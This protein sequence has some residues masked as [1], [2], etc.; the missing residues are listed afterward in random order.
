[1]RPL[2]LALLLVALPAQAQM[3]KCVDA[4]GVTQY[5]DK[6]CADGKGKAV[7]I[8]AQPPISGKLQGSGDPGAAERDFQ[9]RRIES[10]REE[11]AVAARAEQQKRRCAAMHS[12]LDSLTRYSTISKMNEKGERVYM[13]DATRNAQVEQLKSAIARDCR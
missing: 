12:Q 1:M 4:R 10:A 3:Y 13:D 2:A 6:P 5:S 11:E 9:R 7:D 8:R